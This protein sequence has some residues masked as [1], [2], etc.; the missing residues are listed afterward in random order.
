MARERDVAPSD[1]PHTGRRPRATMLPA[2]LRRVGGHVLLREAVSQAAIEPG[3]RAGGCPHRHPHHTPCSHQAHAR[4]ATHAAAA[5]V[6]TLEDEALP[7]PHFIVGESRPPPPLLALEAA[8]A[9]VKVGW[10]WWEGERE[11]G[12]WRCALALALTPSPL[13]PLSPST[14]LG[15]GLQIR[16][17]H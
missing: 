4:A 14:V 7:A 3:R 8:I 11:G 15:Q 5:A 17:D 16:P 6:A 9:A 10:W 12:G 2:L 1:A 13:S